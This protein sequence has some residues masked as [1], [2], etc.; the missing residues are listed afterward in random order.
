MLY[1]PL[2]MYAYVIKQQSKVRLDIW[3]VALSVLL[4]ATSNK[5]IEMTTLNGEMCTYT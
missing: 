3:E 2:G 4:Q 5:F 1:R